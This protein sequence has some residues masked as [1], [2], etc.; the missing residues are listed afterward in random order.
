MNYAELEQAIKDWINKPNLGKIIPTIIR[1]GQR[2]LEDDLRIRPM[3]YNPTTATV[4]A[5]T[6]SLELPSDYMELM[7]LTLLEGTV[8]HPISYRKDIK[9]M[10]QLA[11]NTDETGLPVMVA[12]V[13]DNLVFDVKTNIAYTRDWSYYRRLPVLVAAQSGTPPG[14]SNWWSVNAEEAFLMACI[15]K[16]RPDVPGVSEAG[17][18]KRE[19]AAAATKE[20]LRLKD[21]SESTSGVTLRSEP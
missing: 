16:A 12:R 1:F 18:E 13:G 7:Y 8:K 19:N 14:N 3:E 21:S 15:N 10:I 6:A 20:R 2:D 11:Y 4:N 5:G 17:K 9:A